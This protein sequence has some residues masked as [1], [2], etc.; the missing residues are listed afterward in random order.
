MKSV[1][2]INGSASPLKCG[3]GFYGEIISKELAKTCEVHLLTTSGLGSTDG[4]AGLHHIKNW[5]VARL[6]KITDI[7]K[8]IRPD[9]VHIQYPAVG[10]GRQLGINFLPLYLR[11]FFRKAP[12]VLT[13][14]EYHSSALLGKIRTVITALFVQKIIVSNQTDKNSLPKFLQKKTV[15]IPIGSTVKKVAKNPETFADLIK[16]YDLDG[17]LPTVVY[18]GFTN[19][20]KGVHV[21]AEAS[22]HTQANVLLMT[23]LSSDDAYQKQVLNSVADAKKSG[24]SL[25]VTGYVADRQ[26]S[27]ILQECDILV[28][29]QPLPITGKSSTPIVGALHGLVVVSTASQDAS[30]NLP[31]LHNTNAILLPVMDAPH[32]AAAINDLVGNTAQL[33][34]IKKN[35]P[36]LQEYFAWSAIA[37]K[38][39]EL[40]NSIF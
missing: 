32:L 38:H 36:T 7:I 10:F 31:Y 30:L 21:L 35:L 2:F 17:T 22:A 18:F 3:V 4:I 1:L 33:Q 9:V 37:K 24:A 29:P 39:T 13:Q 23:D 40:Y 14:H 6:P 5:K 20:A 12:I 15:I 27:E 11:I 19:R 8:A 25:A 28:L 16:K 34:T 26:A